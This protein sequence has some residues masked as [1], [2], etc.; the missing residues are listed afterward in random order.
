MATCETATDP[1]KG[2]EQIMK[3][4]IQ[5]R[6]NRAN[7]HNDERK[8]QEYERIQK[9]IAERHE[10]EAFQKWKDYM[11]FEIALLSL[12]IVRFLEEQRDTNAP[13]SVDEP[14]NERFCEA[15]SILPSAREFAQDCFFDC[16]RKE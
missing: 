6:I 3:P 9:M 16:V 10:T 1:Q 12:Q 11:H 8:S 4:S 2:R 13:K 5:D 15:I 14:W 7:E